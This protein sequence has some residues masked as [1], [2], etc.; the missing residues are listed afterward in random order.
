MN[1]YK[2]ILDNL[3]WINDLNDKN[4]LFKKDMLIEPFGLSGWKKEHTF[5][6]T[7]AFNHQPVPLEESLKYLQ[8]WNMWIVPKKDPHRIHFRIEIKVKEDIQADEF[9]I[10]LYNIINSEMNKHGVAVRL[11]YL[12]GPFKES[13]NENSYSILMGT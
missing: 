4:F 11:H 10:H 12:E 13:K 7:K 8:I 5:F 9:T 3:C 1:Q 2:E 6:N